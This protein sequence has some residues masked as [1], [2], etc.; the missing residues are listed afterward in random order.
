MPTVGQHIENPVAGDAVTFVTLPSGP[1]GPL[2][3]D[4]VT[5]PGGDGP[6]E[7]VHPHAS[8]T[9]A[10]AEGCILVEERGVR[11]VVHAGETRT[12]APGTPHR[13]LSHG[14]VPATTRVT[15]D[16]GGSMGPFLETFYELASAGRLDA[17]GKPALLQ[18][19]VTFAAVRDDIR[20]TIAP[21]P[22]QRVMQALLGP[23]GRARGLK[24][25]YVTGEL[26]GPQPSR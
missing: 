21:W 12:V 22:A 7:H 1:S 11:T 8:E 20:P 17:E 16:P 4:M 9:F 25:F 6:P 14:A 2:V 19:A 10:V 3:A 24:P 26:T 18:I 13:F 5:V 23:V 15:L